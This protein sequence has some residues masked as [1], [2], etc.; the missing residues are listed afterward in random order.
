MDDAYNDALAFVLRWEGGFV[1]QGGGFYSV[2]R[3]TTNANVAAVPTFDPITNEYSVGQTF[4]N[5]FGT[6]AMAREQGKTNSATSQ[7]FFN[8]TNN[9]ALDTVDGGFTVFG[10]AV[11]DTNVLHRFNI[12]SPTNG[13]FRYLALQ[14]PF[15][16]LPV[17]STNFTST[18]ELVETL[19]YVDVTLLHVQIES[20]ASGGR[21]ISWESVSNKVNH[22]EFTA[23]MPPVW[24]ELIKTNG[25]GQTISVSDPQ[26][27][28]TNRF[29]RVRVEY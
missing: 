13:I 27:A 19:V 4:S 29:Y 8:L 17:L 16:E 7:F 12:T 25:T 14:P 15:N 10:R 20:L 5:G 1:I 9:A 11:G 22:V 24:Q 6:I 21:Q 3:L 18:E 2:N 23:E 26:L 28:A